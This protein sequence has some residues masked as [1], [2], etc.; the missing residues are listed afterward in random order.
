MN[1]YSNSTSRVALW[2]LNKFNNIQDHSPKYV[3]GIAKA[4]LR[5][6]NESD[7]K[8]Q[9]NKL[10]IVMKNIIKEC[11]ETDG[12]CMTDHSQYIKQLVDEMKQEEMYKKWH[13]ISHNF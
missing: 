1:D 10:T 5:K 11:A 6:I 12:E 9:Y 3:I 8:H 7:D 2:A 4:V 13:Y